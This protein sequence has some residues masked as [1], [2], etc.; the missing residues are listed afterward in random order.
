MTAKPIIHF[1]FIVCH[2]PLHN[3]F[4]LTGNG[5][6]NLSVSGDVQDYSGLS[7]I[8]HYG[9]LMIN[10]RTRNNPNGNLA[11]I[12]EI[13]QGPMINSLTL[14]HG[15]NLDLSALPLIANDLELRYCDIRD[16]SGLKD[17]PISRLRLY[18]CPLLSSSRACRIRRSSENT[19]ARSKS[20]A[21]RA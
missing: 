17:R 18:N 3:H 4:A 2:A 7:A 12:L 10:P 9:R 8:S 16:L 15:S 11:Q 1:F 6:L 19:A 14:D 5:T 20:T 13:L 21:A